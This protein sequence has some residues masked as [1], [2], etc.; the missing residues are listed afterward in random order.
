LQLFI[1]SANIKDITEAN[2]LGI[3]SGVTTNPTLLSKEHMIDFN[4]N[5]SIV[6]LISEICK[7]VSGPVN[8]EV[9]N[10][11][12]NDMLDEARMY[13][14]INKNIV[15]K[16]P[17]SELGLQAVKIL[18]KENIKTNMTLIFSVCQGLLASCA[19]ANYIS[20]FVGRL[21]DV[22]AKGVE[23]IKNLS[24]V[25]Q[26]HTS[27]IAASIR[28]PIDVFEAALCGANVATVPYS[29]IMQMIHH[30][31]TDAGIDSF[32]KAINKHNTQS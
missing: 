32:N 26:K 25:I 5:E 8:V 1:D 15:I 17:M 12:L 28:N 13:A 10:L 9:T 20:P 7:I 2:K 14:S 24:L 16:I 6:N 29:T 21:N 23:L 31:L 4:N 22:S 30:P 27:I 3:I 18:S 19:G 11:K